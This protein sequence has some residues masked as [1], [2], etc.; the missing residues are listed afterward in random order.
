MA[1]EPELLITM[2]R[3]FSG[4]SE[5]WRQAPLEAEVAAGEQPSQGQKPASASRSPEGEGLSQGA[6][7]KTTLNAS[8]TGSHPLR[9]PG[10]SHCVSSP[11]QP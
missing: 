8:G 1:H 4:H 5:K 9:T 11:S 7:L 6:G 2:P 3:P 10:P